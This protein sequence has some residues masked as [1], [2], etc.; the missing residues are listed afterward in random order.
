MS[1]PSSFTAALT[2]MGLDPRFLGTTEV[3]LLQQL[4][5]LGAATASAVG[6]GVNLNNWLDTPGNNIAYTYYGSTN[7]IDTQVFKSGSTTVATIT[8]T[9][10]GG[11]VANDDNILTQVRS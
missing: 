4:V 11:G 2:A 1:L 3:P 7:N 6:A 8:Y 9:Y 5:A 10:V